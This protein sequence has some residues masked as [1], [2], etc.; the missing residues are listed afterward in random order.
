LGI[1]REDTAAIGD[2][3]NDIPML[4]WAG[5]SAAVENAPDAVK[6]AAQITMPSHDA[7]GVSAYIEWLFS[8]LCEWNAGSIVYNEGRA[9]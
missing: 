7:L 2:Y 9:V 5:H 8:N 1:A 4:E 6:A 3:Y